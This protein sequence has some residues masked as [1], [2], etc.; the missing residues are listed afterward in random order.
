MGPPFTHG[1]GHGTHRMISTFRRY[2]ET[3]YVRAF[4]FLMVA[5]FVLW[6]VGDMLRVV[7]TSTWAAKVAGTTIE[8]QTLQA[9]YQRAL[10]TATRDLPPGQEPTAELRR[11]IV[12]QTLQ[13]MIGQLAVQKELRDLRVAVPDAVLVQATRA[14]PAFRGQDGAFDRARFDVALRNNG[15]TEQSFLDTMR[16]DIARRQLVDA[17]TAGARAPDSALGPIYA[18]QFEKRSA[19]V[20]AFPF[21]ATPEPPVPDEAAT[22]RWYDN[23]PD[24]YATPE[25]RRVKLA[26]LSPRTLAPEVAITDKDVVDAY[27]AHQAEYTTIGR[28]SARVI[29]AQD[30]TQARTLADQWR[31]GADWPAMEAAAKAAGAAAIA[32]DN[33]AEREF[34]DKDLA[35]AV[36]STA[37]NT[38]PPPVKGGLG[39]FVIQVTAQ[40]EGGTAP[41][42]D[43]KDKLRGRVLTDRALELVYER[44]NKLDGLFAN[45]TAL[46][47]LP[48]GL[49]VTVATVTLDKR[50][51]GQEETQAAIPGE[52]EMRAAAAAAAFEAAKGDAPRLV[53]VQTPSSGGSGYL[54]L[55]VEDI[56][57]AGMKPFEAVREAAGEDWRHD[58]RRR[59]AEQAAAAM[60]KAIKDGHSFS[61]AAQDAGVTP[62]LSAQVTRSEPDA[63]L[64]REV[65]QVLFG[66]KKGEPTMVE[67]AEGFLVATPVEIVE[68]DP[69]ADAAGYE[70]VRAVVARTVGNDMAALLT[71]ALRL[72]ASPRINQTNVDQIAQP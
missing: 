37:V 59:S 65:H 25:Y 14:I 1:R 9:E 46:D 4:F 38:I 66:L 50:G 18:T 70:R 5:S 60:L 32:L 13:R 6:G 52:E 45:G 2:L 36:F 55:V 47:S 63:S 62:S 10:S 17:V 12:E 68:P 31:A 3:W 15:L 11:Q 44:A 56:I 51:N 41:F 48:P 58:Q 26:V 34:P 57:P 67:T 43:V 30:E 61:E 19:D 53:E 35:K 40:V 69:K 42:E 49:G 39:W 20:V 23:H 27:A 71:E 8:A 24:L 64:P 7:G 72:R 33:A 54:A 28:R 16:A 29:S 21:A 22:R